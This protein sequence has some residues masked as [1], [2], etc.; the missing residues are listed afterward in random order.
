M[1][2]QG[3]TKLAIYHKGPSLDLGPMPTVFYFSLSGDES[4]ELDPYNQPAVILNDGNIRIFSFSLPGHGI[5]IP[6]NKVMG[7][8]ADEFLKNEHFFSN[9]IE[10]AAANIDYLIKQNYIDDRHLALAGLSRGAFIACH[11]AAKEKRVGT[12]LGFAP[13]TD[14]SSLHEFEN[15][16]PEK[17]ERLALRSL[18]HS[19]SHKR[20]RFYVGNHDTRVGT[21]KCFHFIKTLAENEYGKRIRP[22]LAEMVIYPSIGHKGH[23]TPP[24]IFAEG[25]AWLKKHL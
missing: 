18:V 12:I 7:L 11:I 17:L 23:G 14:L 5:D 15:I 2:I 3:L 13:L 16:K 24:E 20:I 4:L 25:A 10:E 9:F 8:W 6:N 22:A 1:T 21:D 19:L